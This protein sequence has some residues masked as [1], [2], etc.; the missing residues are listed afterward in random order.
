[1]TPQPNSVPAPRR[2]GRI[3]K[4]PAWRQ[5][6]ADAVSFLRRWL[7]TGEPWRLHTL[8]GEDW[9]N[10]VIRDPDELRDL[11][12]R[13]NGNCSLYFSP[14]LVRGDAG[15]ATK[16]GVRAVLALGV[17]VDVPKDVDPASPAWHEA[18]AS[19]LAK[20]QNPPAGV[21]VPSVVVDTGG[22]G[23]A[24]WFLAEP[25]EVDGKDGPQTLEVEDRNRWLADRLGGDN[26][27]NVDRV[28]RLPF[29]T[30]VP[31]A[32][33]LARGRVP[34]EA[35]LVKWSRSLTYDLSEF[36]KAAPKAKANV[37]VAEVDF[38]NLP[39][40]AIPD[41][42]RDDART[43]IVDGV[44][45]GSDRSAARFGV[46]CE[47]LRHGLDEAQVAAVVLAP[48][49]G[50]HRA[51]HEDKDGS[52]RSE[53]EARRKFG[54]DLRNAMAKPDVQAARS[55]TVDGYAA[56]AKERMAA[57][58][59][60]GTTNT[61][62]E[63]TAASVPVLPSK[64]RAIDSSIL[65]QPSPPAL[66]KGLF[67]RGEL[68]IPFG[69]PG[70]GK[71][72]VMLDLALAIA[73]GLPTWAGHKIVGRGPVVYVAAEGK[74]G[75][76]LRLI[77]WARARNPRHPE[78]E[79]DKL[80]GFFYVFEEATQ[81]LE[82]T[83]WA[84][85][86]A[87]VDALG[88]TPY[89]IFFD[90][91][92]RCIAGVDENSQ[93]EMSKAIHCTDELRALG[94]ATFLVHHSKKDGTQV[95]GS[96]VL[97]GAADVMFHVSRGGSGAPIVLDF[98]A[99]S[100]GKMKE[101]EPPAD[102]LHFLLRSVLLGIDS[103]GDNITSAVVAFEPPSKDRLAAMERRMLN[104]FATLEAGA[105]ISEA[106]WRERYAGKKTTSTGGNFGAMVRKLGER[107]FVVKTKTVGTKSFYSLTPAGELLI[108]R[109][110]Q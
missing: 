66:V 5:P 65:R 100:G 70:S 77:A 3:F 17:D 59:K 93:K 63:Q 110:T 7:P 8:V 43:L 68:V 50:I 2:V 14:F 40:T 99:G 75:L 47:L 78:Q 19:I 102:G 106:D 44:P 31:D 85:F 13:E 61:A 58:A 56:R 52:E 73:L 9:R 90:T 26:C 91:F 32:K 21:P 15:K 71:T 67:H 42:I 95:R 80:K 37:D 23:Q 45:A 105:E 89:A 29:T 34:A 103:D 60:A 72:F 20:L 16:D 82:P 104:V 79:L 18:H 96:S 35:V 64:L 46:L 38:Q 88:V 86:R 33:K 54:V 36:E 98:D 81:F 74:R 92:S 57:K 49:H 94:I 4:L 62:A 41:G 25:F 84:T 11:I 109:R 53:N 6:P 12:E 76:Y 107:G 108:E 69:D 39:E 55:A 97:R 101:G 51:Y 1:M 83:E 10:H 27:H 22:G 30:N 28:M 48:A 87:E 24:F